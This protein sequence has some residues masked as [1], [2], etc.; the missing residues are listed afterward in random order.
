MNPA[1]I[2][3]V[4]LALV[5][6]RI[7]DAVNLPGLRFHSLK[8]EG[9]GRYAVLPAIVGPHSAGMAKMRSRLTWRIIA[10]GIESAVEGA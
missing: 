9:K 8:G 2:R 3:R 7:P 4:L 5:G 1:R 10:D 6:A